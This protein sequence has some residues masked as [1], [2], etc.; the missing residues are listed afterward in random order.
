MYTYLYKTQMQIRQG[1]QETKIGT[2]GDYR[3]GS[4]IVCEQNKR[5]GKTS[6]FAENL[7]K[8]IDRPKPQ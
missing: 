4:G 3:G 2:P 8:A 1:T 6:R 7:L 5:K